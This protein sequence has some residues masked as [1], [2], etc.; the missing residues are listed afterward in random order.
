M[1]RIKSLG[2]TISGETSHKALLTPY[3][4]LIADQS[5]DTTK[6]QFGEPMSS[7]DLVIGMWVGD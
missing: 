2:A 3:R 7:L 6:V 5:N 4:E 1:S